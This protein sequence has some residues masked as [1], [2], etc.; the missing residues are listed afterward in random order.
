MLA[1][2]DNI[3]TVCTLDGQIT[4]QNKASIDY[5]GNL[6]KRVLPG[7][8]GSLCMLMRWTCIS[9]LLLMRQHVDSY[10]AFTFAGP[11][12]QSLRL[13]YIDSLLGH[14]HEHMDELMEE[15]TLGNMWSGCVKVPSSL[16]A[17]SMPFTSTSDL[18]GGF[19]SMSGGNGQSEPV[20]DTL[21][22]LQSTVSRVQAV[23]SFR[24]SQSSIPSQTSMR[25]RFAAET[26][27]SRLTVI[28][29]AGGPSHAAGVAERRKSFSGTRVRVTSRTSMSIVKP[30]MHVCEK[31]ACNPACRTRI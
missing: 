23:A 13:S 27:Q 9:V 8:N 26:V 29:L 4:Y 30:A 1:H 19:L 10:D 6:Q 2:V 17:P 21:P 24:A 5:A 28:P 18:G 11:D 22:P 15:I 12:S 3:L 25:S 7:R 14:D 20:K 16:Q 31:N